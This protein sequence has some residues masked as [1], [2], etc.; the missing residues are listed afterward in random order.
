M[1]SSARTVSIAS[2]ELTWPNK[3]YRWKVSSQWC[4]KWLILMNG[5]KPSFT[6]GR[7]QEISSQR[8]TLERSQCSP[9]LLWKATRTPSTRLSTKWLVWSG[10]P[11]RPSQMTSSRSA[12]WSYKVW[13]PQASTMW[14]NG[15]LTVKSLSKV[16]RWF[17][18]LKTYSSKLPALILGEMC[19]KI[20]TT[21]Y[22]YSKRPSRK[23][24]PI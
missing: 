7:W 8:S 6:C 13:T 17:R 11:N 21:S 5:V 23:K 16:A 10:G 20:I 1:E 2:I 12:S 4:L 14:S 3:W 22:K 9:K 24:C 18:K 19:P 15:S